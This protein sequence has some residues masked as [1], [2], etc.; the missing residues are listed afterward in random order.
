M[1]RHGRV[2]LSIIVYDELL[3]HDTNRHIPGNNRTIQIV[4][5]PWKIRW[6]RRRQEKVGRGLAPSFL[7]EIDAVKGS[8]DRTLCL[9]F[10]RTPISGI[11]SPRENV[12]QPLMRYSGQRLYH[13]A[14][15]VS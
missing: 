13:H 8:Y 12:C 9:Q 2:H 3:G 11:P 10:T 4:T 14:I 15:K 6:K 5:L 7:G 1:A